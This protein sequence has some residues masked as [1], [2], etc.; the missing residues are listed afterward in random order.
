MLAV[1]DVRFIIIGGLAGAF[2]KVGWEGGEGLA[3]V[4][5]SGM[6][7]SWGGGQ[8]RATVGARGRRLR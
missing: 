5:W 7:G 3:E 2:H 6:S 1:L 8:L 4:G